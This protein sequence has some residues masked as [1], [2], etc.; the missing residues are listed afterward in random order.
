[1]HEKEINE[2]KI[3]IVEVSIPFWVIIVIVLGMGNQSYIQLKSSKP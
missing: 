3:K 2:K 1:M